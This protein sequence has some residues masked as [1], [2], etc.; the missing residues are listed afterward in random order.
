LEENAYLVLGC[1]GRDENSFILC[2]SIENRILK[3][4]ESLVNYNGIMDYI[5]VVNLFD[6]PMLDQ[7]A[8]RHTIYNLQEKF[9]QK[10]KRLW[11]DHQYH[12]IE[13]FMHMHKPCGFYCRLIVV[14]EELE[15]FHEEQISFVI[16]GSPEIVKNKKPINLKSV[17]GR[18]Y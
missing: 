18:K 5:E 7:N 17:R 8:I 6:R 16:N 2:P 12:L 13:R 1:Y 11:T 9:D 3:L 4:D 15:E 10:V 14:P